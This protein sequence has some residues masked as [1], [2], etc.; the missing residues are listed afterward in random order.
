MMLVEAGR[1]ETMSTAE[2]TEVGGDTVTTNWKELKIFFGH[3][4][5]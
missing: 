2:A 1:G 3:L 4:F 5:G